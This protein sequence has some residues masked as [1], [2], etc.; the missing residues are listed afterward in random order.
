MGTMQVL[1]WLPLLVA[2]VT[3][4]INCNLSD[5]YHFGKYNLAGCQSVLCKDRPVDAVA[6]A[7][8]LASESGVDLQELTLSNVSNLGYEHPERMK[9][10]ADAIESHPSLVSLVIE[11][12]DIQWQGA[13][14]I[15]WALRSNNVLARL[16]MGKCGIGVG[17]AMSVARMLETNKGIAVLEVGFND[18][19][20]EGIAAI[21]EAIRTAQPNIEQLDL[22]ANPIFHE[23]A[24]E[25]AK[26]LKENKF[27][28]GLNLRASALND[29]GAVSIA[30]AL[31]KNEK[32][33][34]IDLWANNISDI[35]AAAIGKML[36]HN[37]V[38]EVLNLWQNRI[39]D[40]GAIAIAQGL[41]HNMGL[42]SIHLGRNANIGD[43][44]AVEFGKAMKTNEAMAFIDFGTQNHEVTFT[45]EEPL[46]KAGQC[47]A[48]K[49]GEAC[50]AEALK[51][52]PH[53]VSVRDL[54]RSSGIDPDKRRVENIKK[55]NEL[56]EIEAKMSPEQLQEVKRLQQE[57]QERQ[58]AEL[59]KQ[60]KKMEKQQKKERLERNKE[61]NRVMADNEEYMATLPPDKQEAV[62]QLQAKQLAEDAAEAKAAEAKRKAKGKAKAKGKRKSKGGAVKDEV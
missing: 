54:M 44:A 10:I 26:M 31:A 37:D 57:E 47:N 50:R 49:K 3:A 11:N 36:E 52:L 39:T 13:D 51:K 17:G 12:T 53:R 30:G 20:P 61:G 32:L 6:L 38:L 2:T 28:R 5:V 62:R 41:P 40:I 56:A 8:A 34:H 60:Q 18:I 33:S 23:G 22:S 7:E 19:G 15:A 29:A 9:A 55:A 59:A 27:L 35:G 4:D 58:R 25:L 46:R 45:F 24:W 1:R 16:V 48:M 14:A 21:A 42:K 43:A